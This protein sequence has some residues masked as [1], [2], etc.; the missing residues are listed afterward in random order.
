MGWVAFLQADW[1]P[2]I[3]DRLI[4]IHADHLSTMNNGVEG[5]SFNFNKFRSMML[6][7]K[8][9]VQVDADMVVG[10]HCDRLFDATA[11]ES[12]AQ[13]VHLFN[14]PLRSYLVR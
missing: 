12:T 3:F 13:S 6:R 14:P 10:A 1:D 8:T 5:I 7:I 2:A 11:R 4:I 9:A